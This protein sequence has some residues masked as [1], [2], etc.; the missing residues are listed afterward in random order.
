MAAKK[1]R[2]DTADKPQYSNSDA[3]ALGF[4]AVIVSE[5]LYFITTGTITPDIYV[6]STSSANGVLYI[7][8]LFILPLLALFIYKLSNKK[9]IPAIPYLFAVFIMWYLLIWYLLTW[10]PSLHKP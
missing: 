3:V 9:H 8:S 5:V 4:F 10:V 7:L 2:K 1:T 6:Y